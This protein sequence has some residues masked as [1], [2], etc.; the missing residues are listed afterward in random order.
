M[1]S[2]GMYL[3]E[4]KNLH[5]EHIEDSVFNEGAKGVSDAVNFLKSVVD[6]LRGNSK[7]GVDITVKWDGA[8]AIFCGEDPENG[9]FFVAT[10]RC[11]EPS[12]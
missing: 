3:S 4:S 5:M 8:P 10:S 6:M 1:K 2:F 7:S 12:P 9:K 11:T